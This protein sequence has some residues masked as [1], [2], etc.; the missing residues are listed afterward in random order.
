MAQ[1][2]DQLFMF[3]GTI[4]FLWES[5]AVVPHLKQRISVLWPWQGW[6]KHINPS[7]P[8]LLSQRNVFGDAGWA[9]IHC[10]LSWEEE[11]ICDPHHCAVPGA[12]CYQ[13]HGHKCPLCRCSVWGIYK[14]KR[15]M[16]K[17]MYLHSDRMVYEVFVYCRLTANSGRR[18]WVWP[19]NITNN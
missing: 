14:Q 8:A 19:K 1:N 2:R 12:L 11:L 13:L 9:G 15:Q 18:I 4:N 6:G 3:K 5:E 17:I 16:A 10:C 7:T